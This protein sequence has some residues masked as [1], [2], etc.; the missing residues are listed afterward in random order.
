MVLIVLVLI[1]LFEIGISSLL[2][3]IVSF[4]VDDNYKRHLFYIKSAESFGLKILISNE[5]RFLDA[6]CKKCS[7]SANN[8]E[9]NATVFFHGF[10]MIP[11]SRTQKYKNLLGGI[12]CP[13]KIKLM[14]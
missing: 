7:C 9:I 6:F 5:F 8:P 2:I 3:E 14:Q 12:L 13:E 11:S 10:D 4:A 1:V